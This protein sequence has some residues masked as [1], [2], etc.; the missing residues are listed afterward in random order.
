LQVVVECKAGHLLL[1]DRLRNI[2]TMFV[3]DAPRHDEFLRHSMDAGVLGYSE[4]PVALPEELFVRCK[5]TMM[6]TDHGN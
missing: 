3:L 6:S 1:D 4:L 5:E 2:G